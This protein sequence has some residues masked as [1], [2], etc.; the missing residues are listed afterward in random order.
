MTALAAPTLA[1]AAATDNPPAT[2][3]GA[4]PAHGAAP[5]VLRLVSHAGAH[6]VDAAGL[7][8]FLA[9]GAEQVL[10][11]HGDPVRFPEVLDVAVVLP[12]LCRH[13]Q[14]QFGH[15]Y[16]M[17]VVARADEDALARRFG[18]THWPALVFL[19]GGRWVDTLS[20][21]QDWD[22]Y[23]QRLQAIAA[24]PASRPPIAVHAAGQPAAGCH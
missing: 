10:F 9:R 18:V 16:D 24:R 19:R 8:S 2:T 3:A 1:A 6:W 5:L 12:E 7:D 17:G 13:A 22:V 23:L 4:N 11:F 21:M 20:G 15:A 14:R